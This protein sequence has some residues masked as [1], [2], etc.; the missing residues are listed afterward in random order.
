MKATDNTERIGKTLIQH[1]F[2]YNYNRVFSKF[3]VTQGHYYN[4]V[5][6]KPIQSDFMRETEG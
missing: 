5:P 3:M 2:C 1:Q 6:I 4:E